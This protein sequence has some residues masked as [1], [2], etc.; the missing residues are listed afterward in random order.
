MCIRDRAYGG[1]KNEVH[2][3][4]KEVRN[5]FHI[6]LKEAVTSGLFFGSTG[7]VGNTAML[8][9]LLV[10]TSMIQSGTMTVGELSSFMMYAVYTGS[11]LFGLSSFYS[12]LMKL[13]LI[14]I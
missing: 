10:G 1:E 14:H 13:S 6:G 4:A 12:E 8:S 7:L 9:L 3:Y 5:V 11:S 2:R